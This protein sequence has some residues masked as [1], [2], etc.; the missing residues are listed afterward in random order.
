MENTYKY[1]YI[2]ICTYA[3]KE[4]NLIDVDYMLRERKMQDNKIDSSAIILHK[5][6]FN[7][8]QLCIT[9]GMRMCYRHR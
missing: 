3:D 6:I 9:T 7:H 4:K 2:C 5:K 1:K 8:R